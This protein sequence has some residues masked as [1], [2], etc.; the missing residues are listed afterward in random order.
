MDQQEQEVQQKEMKSPASGFCALVRARGQPAG[1]QLCKKGLGGS[2][3]Q[4]IEHEP[5][6]YPH[7]KEHQWYPTLH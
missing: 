5:E 6:M 2:G 1:K 7:G 3:E 4:Q